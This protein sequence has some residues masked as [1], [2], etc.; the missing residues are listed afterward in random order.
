MPISFWIWILEF[1]KLQYCV[2]VLHWTVLP[3]ILFIYAAFS[4]TYT[5]LCR[6]SHVYRSVDSFDWLYLLAMI[7][8]LYTVKK[9]FHLQVFRAR[10]RQSFIQSKY[11]SFKQWYCPIEHCPLF[12]ITD[13]HFIRCILMYIVIQNGL[14]Y[15]AHDSGYSNKQDK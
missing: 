14:Q 8:M 9:L 6:D 15:N 13:R 2:R 10:S 3:C 1:I 5:L 7:N 12:N 4:S 11:I